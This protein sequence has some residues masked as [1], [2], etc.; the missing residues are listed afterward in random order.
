MLP[1]VAAFRLKMPSKFS[2][3]ISPLTVVVA[4]SVKAGAEPGAE[5]G[6]RSTL[7]GRVRVISTASRVVSGAA[8]FT[9]RQL[10]GGQPASLPFTALTDMRANSAAALLLLLAWFFLM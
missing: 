10:V 9:M 8:A 2:T 7:K 4:C 5:G 3:L 1:W 6:G